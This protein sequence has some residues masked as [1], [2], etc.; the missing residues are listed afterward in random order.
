[1]KHADLSTL[2]STHL[3]VFVF[4]EKRASGT[5]ELSTGHDGDSVSEEIGF[6]HVVRGQN[7]GASL[8]VVL[9]QVPRPSSSRGVHPTSR[10]VQDYNL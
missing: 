6:V 9:D 8:P 7:D 5:H 10:F 3:T 2:Y 1:M 4:E